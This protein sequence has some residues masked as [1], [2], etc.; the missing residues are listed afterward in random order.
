[1]LFGELQQHPTMKFNPTTKQVFTNSGELI[2]K[3]DCPFR[4]DW[5]G[6]EKA[7]DHH[8][9]CTVCGRAVL[10]TEKFSDAEL[11]ARVKEDPQTCLKIGLNQE[12]VILVSDGLKT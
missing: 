2:K 9:S 4:M 6:M 7:S 1:M 10:D 5:E 11:L 8:R 3:L 12:N